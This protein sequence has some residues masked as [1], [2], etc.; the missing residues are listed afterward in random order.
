MRVPLSWL[1]D[2]V[3][4]PMADRDLADRLTMAGLEVSSV[5]SIGVDWGECF[6]GKV[7]SADQHPNADRLSLCNVDIG[8]TQVQVVCGAPNVAP[9]QTIAFAKPGSLLFDARDGTKQILKPAVIRGIRSDGMICSE[10]ELGLGDD[11]H[12]ILV[13]D[14][15]FPPGTPLASV[16]G[17]T[18]LDIETTANRPDA[19]SLIGIAYEV[20]AISNS[21]VRF[22]DL[23]Y[24]QGLECIE[25]SVSV[26]IEDPMLCPRYTATIVR[27]MR[28]ASSPAWM[29][30][31]LRK[32]GFRPINNIVDITNYVMLELGQ[33]LHA[34]D[35]QRLSSK[36]IVVRVAR[37]GETI[38]TLD[39]VTRKLDSTT[40]LITNK[41]APIAIAGII[42]G[43]NSE[44]VDTSETILL[45]AASFHPFNTRASSTRLRLRT[46]AS[47][48]FEKGLR[49]DLPL[50]GLRRATR[51]LSMFAG[52]TPAKGVIDVYP[53]NPSP[54]TPLLTQARLQGTLGISIRLSEA[55]TALGRLGFSATR[56][57]TGSVKVTVPPWR[58]DVSLE[59]DL[60]EEVARVIGYDRIP[61][62]PLGR[63][64]P[65][66]VPNPMR[67]MKKSIMEFLVR[68][69]FQEVV[70][71]PLISASDLAKINEDPNTMLALA[72][73][74]SPEHRFLRTTLIPS[75]LNALSPN[76]RREQGPI[77]LCELARVYL[78]RNGKL[79]DERETLVAVLT[80]PNE[81][82]SW[83]GQPRMLD[84]FD[85]K[86]VV[87]T[88][89]ETLGV[90]FEYCPIEHPIMTNS[91]ATQVMI[92]GKP[93]GLLGEVN[94][95][96]LRS[97]DIDVESI[98]LF[99][100][101]LGSLVS[102]FEGHGKTFRAL[103]RYP[104]ATRDVALVADIGL[105]ALSIQTLIE[106]HPLVERAILFDIYTGDQ[107]P[108]GKRS[109]NYSIVLQSANRTLA[110][111]EIQKAMNMVLRQL[112]SELKVTLRQGL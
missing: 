91:R 35:Y 83:R 60:I 1:R 82:P 6:I 24:E 89:L 41:E 68:S 9:G 25:D 26:R 87:D 36:R 31:R 2:F 49:P 107:V 17:D 5:E 14:D 30:D 66:F 52:G 73:P 85:A 48:R 23:N 99:Q 105:P 59:D 92:A 67:T 55:K 34:F 81:P 104:E 51:L 21:N 3:D 78:P 63:P 112:E 71:Y 15:T 39:K 96:V 61:A 62:Q 29:Q 80:G 90:R 53:S 42:G 84:F 86:G 46:E 65:S 54:V 57:K 37:P 79:P 76:I 110:T 45:E 94:T 50:I 32:A 16:L 10:R 58:S 106:S 109:L 22:P 77:R 74:L 28:I 4:W 8:A 27:G 93:V 43:A 98:A 72:N 102:P 64:I 11:H 19:L 111:K 40:L 18:I 20:A 95:E 56:H 33:P 70:T 38:E 101:D 7:V 47:L 103:P 88:L 100:L 13:L 12:G 75:I 108:S 69:A 44:V 97:F